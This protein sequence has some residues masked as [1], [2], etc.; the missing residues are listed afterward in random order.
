MVYRVS[1][2]PIPDAG[3]HDPLGEESPGIG[4]MAARRVQG[5]FSPGSRLDREGIG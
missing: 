5:F 4:R 2:R 1:T 3:V